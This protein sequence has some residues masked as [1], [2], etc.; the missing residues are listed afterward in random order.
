MVEWFRVDFWRQLLERATAWLI[1]S[2]PTILVILVLA[3]ALSRALGFAVSRFRIF[4]R[5]HGRHEGESVEEV[6][7]RVGTLASI[8]QRTA[9][10]LLWGVVGMIVLRELG[11]DVAPLI[12]GAGVAGLAVGFGAQNLVRD[13]LSGFFMIVDNQ[14]R[15]GDVVVINGTAGLVESLNLR[16]TTLRDVEGM[17]H[18]FP[19]GSINSLSNRTMGWSAAVFDIGVAYHEDT[20]RVA[21]LMQEVGDALAGDPA[22]AG[23]VLERFEIL[24]VDAFQESA[25]VVKA[26]LKTRPG[27]QW[28]LGREYRRRLKKAFEAAGIE[29]PFPQRVLTLGATARPLDVRV[30]PS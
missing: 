5:Q 28:R 14:I 16:R 30:R 19:N 9:S 10:F 15:A 25:V 8:L 26:R 3:L 21:A 17:V 12:A 11:V 20:D 6:E 2:G 27:E 4:M 7:K 18:I 1:A 13:V 29:V 24:G 23:A 22:Y